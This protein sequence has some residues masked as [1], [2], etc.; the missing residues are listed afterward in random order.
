MTIFISFLHSNPIRKK[1]EKRPNKS[2]PAQA[3]GQKRGK[4]NL[5]DLQNTFYN[6]LV[7]E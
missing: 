4:K 7:S 5:S 6:I 2:L 3:G 1:L